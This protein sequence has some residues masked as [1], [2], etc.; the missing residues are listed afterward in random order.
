M[1]GQATYNIMARTGYIQYHDNCNHCGIMASKNTMEQATH[2]IMTIVIT[3]PL[4]L[5]IMA[6]NTKWKI[7]K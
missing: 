6:K 7:K 3:V 1:V 4:E 2:N 5:S